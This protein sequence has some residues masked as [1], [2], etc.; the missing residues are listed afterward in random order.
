MKRFKCIVAYDGTH[1]NG[2]QIQQNQRTVQNEIQK[3]LKKVHKGEEIIIQASGRTDTKVHANGQVI[4][5]DTTFALTC[6]QWKRAL[7]TQ[8]PPDIFIKKV[9]EVNNDFHARYNVEKKEY[10]Y[11]IWNH[12][13]ENVFRRQY[14]YHYPYQ[15]NIQRMEEALQHFVG[16]YDFTSFCSAKTEKENKVRTIFSATLEQVNQEIVISL[17]G[18]GFLHNMVRIIIGTLIEVGQG[19]REIHS[20]DQALK[21]S[22]RKLAGKTAP[23]H[24]LSLWE[25]NYNN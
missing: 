17:V 21:G 18:S 1:F 14:H 23:P 11:V 24:G 5:F 8:L 3:A 25:V 20:I 16:T 2:F 12:K 19:R 9:E 4:H 22:N 13:D 15:L 6:E 10:R 7:N